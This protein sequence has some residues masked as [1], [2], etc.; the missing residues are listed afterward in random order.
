MISYKQITEI[1][2]AMRHASEVATYHV[3]AADSKSQSIVM[4]QLKKTLKTSPNC[5]IIVLKH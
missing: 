1:T 4:N 5:S 3:S 2:A